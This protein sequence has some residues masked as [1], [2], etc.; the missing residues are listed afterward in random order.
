[1]SVRNCLRNK[2]DNK[3]TT[4]QMTLFRTSVCLF[5]KKTEATQYKQKKWIKYDIVLLFMLRS[6][7]IIVSYSQKRWYVFLLF[8]LHISCV[9]FCL[10]FITTINKTASSFTSSFVSMLEGPRILGVACT[11]CKLYDPICCIYLHIMGSIVC[12]VSPPH[13]SSRPLAW[14]SHSLA[15]LKGTTNLQFS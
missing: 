13:S 8:L 10:S 15:W 2:N 11:Y 6:L 7:S 9:S 1:M 3:M 14:G 4:L 5:Y 12:I